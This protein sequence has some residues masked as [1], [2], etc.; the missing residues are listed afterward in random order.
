V[1]TPVLALFGT[2]SQMLPARAGAKAIEHNLRRGKNRD[3]TVYLIPAANELMRIVPNETG[4]KWDWPR[5]A[6]GYM[7]SVTSWVLER[8]RPGSKPPSN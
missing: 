2:A 4:G 5:A 7:E 8:S 3:V 6:P 1:Q